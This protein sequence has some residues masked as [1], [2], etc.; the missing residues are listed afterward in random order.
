MQSQISNG[1]ADRKQLISEDNHPV[2]SDEKPL[3]KFYAEYRAGRIDKRELEAQIFKHVLENKS[4]FGLIHFRSKDECADFL[5]WLYPRL[6][7]AVERFKPG[8]KACF[9]TYINSI[10][11]MADKEYRIRSFYSYDTE[12]SAWKEEAHDFV[13]AEN[14]PVYNPDENE[15]REIKKL[16][17]PRQALILLLK[18]YYFVQDNLINGIA[19]SLGLTNTELRKMINALHTMRQPCEEKMR[20]LRERCFLQYFRCITFEKRLS[21]AEKGTEKH[22]ILINKVEKH[23]LRL[24]S[25][26]HRLKNMRVEASNKQIAQILGMS[27]SKVDFNVNKTKR[28]GFFCMD[29]V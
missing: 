28:K 3:D 8:E 13:L 21:Y 6:T 4:A 12:K 7:L 9:N 29:A 23:R 15:N 14:E 24:M 25:M 22:T 27:K 19:P 17:N 26:R 1:E 10:M 16:V 5:C 2:K 18:S 11:R 20:I